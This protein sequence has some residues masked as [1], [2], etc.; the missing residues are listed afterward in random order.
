MSKPREYLIIGVDTGLTTGIKV[1]ANRAGREPVLGHDQVDRSDIAPYLASLIALWVEEVGGANV[2]IAVEKYIIT[3]RTATLS[4]QPDALEI[5][6]MVKG[7][8]ATEARRG[9]ITVHQIMKGNLKFASD[10][11]LKRLGWYVPGKRHANDAA[12]Q[13]FALLKMVDPPHWN[14][15]VRSVMLEPEDEGRKTP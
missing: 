2:H 9:A 4:Q 15:L 3:K 12:R 14:D 7:F 8:A 11:M 1:Y 5:T 10:D 13:A 6:G